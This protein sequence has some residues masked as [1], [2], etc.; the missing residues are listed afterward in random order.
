NIVLT[1]PE[2]AVKKPGESHKLSC[3]VS[4][5]DVNGHHMNWVKQVPGEGLE[6]LLSYRKT[7]NTYYA[8][9][10]QGRITFSTESSTTFIEIPNLRVEDTAMYYCARGTGFPQ[11]GYW[12]SGTF[13]TVTSV[14]Q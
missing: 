1:Q 7:Y 8:S 12:G 3:T 9:G 2:S 13:L 11:W 4:G 5:F 6:W 10:I 14:T